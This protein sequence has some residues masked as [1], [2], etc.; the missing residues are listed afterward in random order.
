MPFETDISSKHARERGGGR[1]RWL[2]TGVLV[3]VGLLII[4]QTWWS[5][6]L[7]RPGT[8]QAPTIRPALGPV[9]SYDELGEP[10]QPE[11]VEREIATPLEALAAREAPRAPPPAPRIRSDKKP[12]R[13][14]SV[15]W[16][17]EATPPPAD[18]FRDGRM[19]KLGEGCALRP[20]ASII[21][22][23]L[24]TA[25]NSEIPGQVIAEVMS[26]VYSP[27]LGYENKPLV[28]AGTRVV[29]LISKGEGLTLDRRRIDIVWTEMT[30]RT[31]FGGDT[32]VTQVSLDRAFNAS[33]DGSAGSG[34][35]VEMQYGQLFAFAALTTI[36]NVAQRGV[37]RNDNA[38]ADAAQR[39][40][41]RTIGTVG[42]EVVRRSLDWEPKILIDAGTQVRI[43]IQD[44]IRVC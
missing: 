4:T 8:P 37:I 32:A 44:T 34:G 2:M 29:G 6:W 39:E 25:V 16:R 9:P 3:L 40:V 38:I 5:T 36:F 26:T 28:P 14:G 41:S 20:G 42:N 11:I 12:V 27:D 43:L 17:I 21:P 19:A 31:G 13:L 1:F 7:N 35:R 15:S 18:W 22:A 23:R 30:S 24:L 33:A 10:P